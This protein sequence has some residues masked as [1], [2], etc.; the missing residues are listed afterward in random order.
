MNVLKEATKTNPSQMDVIKEEEGSLK[1][2]T[3]PPRVIP[4]WHSLKLCLIGKAYSGKK[5]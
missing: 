3:P 2:S 1:T 4:N 5:T